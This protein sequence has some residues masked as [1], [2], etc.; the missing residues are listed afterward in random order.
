MLHSLVSKRL[1]SLLEHQ[2]KSLL[3]A[4]KLPVQKFIVLENSSN[5]SNE[6]NSEMLKDARQ[7]VIKAQVPAGEGEGDTLSMT[8]ARQSSNPVS[9]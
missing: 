3:Q 7:V 5:R 4:A 6:Y 2:A 1:L 9:M 8:L